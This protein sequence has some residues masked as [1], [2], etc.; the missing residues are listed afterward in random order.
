[1]KRYSSALSCLGRRTVH[2]VVGPSLTHHQ[3]IRLGP[4]AIRLPLEDAAVAEIV[5]EGNAKV[6]IVQ[7][8]KV[9]WLRRV[10]GADLSGLDFELGLAETSPLDEDVVYNARRS[11]QRRAQL[12]ARHW[13]LLVVATHMLE[14]S[15]LA[16]T[17]FS[18]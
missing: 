9:T 5:G 13:R 1:M 4:F 8:S 10:R 15:S 7:D 17:S 11:C 6:R 2:A 12:C 14:H 18:S 3:E 16:S